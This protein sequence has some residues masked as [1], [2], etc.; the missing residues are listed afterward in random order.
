MIM[1]FVR[2]LRRLQAPQHRVRL[3][4]A[5]KHRDGMSGGVP[6]DG[7]HVCHYPRLVLGSLLFVTIFTPS[8]IQPFSHVSLH[9]FT[10]PP[11]I[12]FLV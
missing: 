11:S 9:F 10:T 5:L 12:T 1:E 8:A 2:R 7:E 4:G 6:S 3:V